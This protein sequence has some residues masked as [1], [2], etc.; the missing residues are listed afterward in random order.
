[1]GKGKGI[2]FF[3]IQREMRR[4]GRDHLQERC[5]IGILKAQL[6]AETVS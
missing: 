1:M 3:P 4:I 2:G 6:Q 5:L